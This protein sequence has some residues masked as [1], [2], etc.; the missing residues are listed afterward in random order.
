MSNA[1][2]RT[3]QQ[4][5]EIVSTI[6]APLVIVDASG[7][8]EVANQKLCELLGNSAGSIE[9]GKFTGR[10]HIGLPE[11]QL[12]E[13]FKNAIET[14]AAPW[15][16]CLLA[17][18][19]AGRN[20]HFNAKFSVIQP[21]SDYVS[22]LVLLSRIENRESAKAPPE[23]STMAEVRSMV[24]GANGKFTAG[25]LEMIGL[26]D[27]RLSLGDRWERLASRAYSIADSILKLRLS[28]EDVFRRDAEGNYIVCFAKLS[29]EPAWF[30]A[31]ALGQEI[32]E[33]LLG[34]DATDQLAEFE[35]DAEIRASMSDVRS[36]TYEIEIQA[37]D[38]D[39]IPDVVDLIKGKII[40]ASAQLRNKAASLL[41]SLA[42]RPT[43]QFTDVRSV[44]GKRVPIKLATF[45]ANCEADAQR[46]RQVY[47][48]APKLLGQ[49]DAML[50]GAVLEHMY[51]IDPA[52][53]P[54]TVID[55]NFQT[56]A[57]PQSAR[58]YYN[59]LGSAI[60]KAAQSLI[61]DVREIPEDLHHGRIAEVLRF[62]RNY[63]RY[64]ALRLTKPSLGNINLTDSRVSL[65]IFDFPELQ[66][67]LRRDPNAG[68]VLFKQLRRHNVRI[69]IDRI[70]G[71]RSL[72]S[73]QEIKPDFYTI[74]PHVNDGWRSE[75]PLVSQTPPSQNL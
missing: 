55:V 44:D 17:R 13:K 35:L 4:L 42:E 70:P 43:L 26:E 61:I 10:F 72:Q 36:T 28:E 62:L 75:L 6:E 46:L 59:I 9:G 64:T 32:R 11:G 23:Q 7:T 22:V 37:E 21:S 16:A 24:A 41:R 31:K 29:N 69:A 14:T 8:I 33:A 2:V 71:V 49:L 53:M 74:S 34:E 40:N 45:N 73:L 58:T 54:A 18:D 3:K 65:A 47:G 19:A 68:T 50:L 57:N 20:I 60:G 12:V 15:C 51:R 67:M 52:T 1:S 30:K 25:H 38:I 66:S 5:H 63:S 27:V 48:N 39:G 56:L